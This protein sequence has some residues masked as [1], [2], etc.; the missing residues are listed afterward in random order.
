MG[1]FPAALGSARGPSAGAAVTGT[2]GVV[3]YLDSL[4]A[5]PGD[6]VVIRVSVLDGERRYRAELV[7]L[8]SGE[9]GPGGPGLKEESIPTALAG[10]YQGHEQPVPIGSCAIVDKS[11]PL[12]ALEL[13]LLIWPTLPGR[14]TQALMALGPLRLALDESGAVTLSVEGESL[15]TNTPLRRRAWHRID[16]RYDP[17]TGAASVKSTPLPGSHAD[18]PAEISG[19]LRRGVRATGPLMIAAA[20]GVDG[21]T[22]HFNGKLEAP[23]LR[24]VGVAAEWDF[25]RAIGKTRIEDRSPHGLHGRTVNAPKRAV[26]GAAWDGSVHDWRQAPSHYGAV[27][28]HADDLYD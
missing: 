14:G 13:S 18:R 4:Y 11:P 22:H 8:I 28:F 1:G 12:Q 10:E 15:S 27:H 6:E 24:S 25:S 3:G 20:E 17:A 5:S 26:T 7:R 23:K 16:A 19:T 21:V 9:T 2:P